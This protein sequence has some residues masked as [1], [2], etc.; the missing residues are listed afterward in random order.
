MEVSATELAQYT[1]VSSA[2]MLGDLAV[3]GP[4]TCTLTYTA[5]AEPLAATPEAKEIMA[6]ITYAPLAANVV[7]GLNNAAVTCVAAA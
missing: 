4:V 5:P 2:C 1:T 7:D 3:T 6:A